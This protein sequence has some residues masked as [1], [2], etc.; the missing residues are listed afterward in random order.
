MI[1]DVTIV[2]DKEKPN[3]NFPYSVYVDYIDMSTR[4]GKS[5][6]W[7]LKG[8]WASVQNPFAVCY[9]G[10]KV[11]KCFYREACKSD[12]EVYQQLIDY[13][14]ENKCSE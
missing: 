11:I 5:E 1:S 4:K 3:L 7:R 14:N 10:K 13:L 8:S 6:G 9:D 2:F 12:N